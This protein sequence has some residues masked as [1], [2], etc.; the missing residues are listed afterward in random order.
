MNMLL[1]QTLVY[2]KY[3]NIKKSYKKIRFRISALTWKEEFELPDGSYSV[4]AIQVF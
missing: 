2:K 3:D 1:Y 4:S